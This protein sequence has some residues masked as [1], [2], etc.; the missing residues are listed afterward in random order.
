M[1]LGQIKKQPVRIAFFIYQVIAN[2]YLCV[3]IQHRL[4]LE[5]AK[6]VLLSA[7]FRRAAK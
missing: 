6:K 2:I 1:F 5:F 4:G 3:I 7:D